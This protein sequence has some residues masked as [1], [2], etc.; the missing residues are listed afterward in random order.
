MGGKHKNQTLLIHSLV[1]NCVVQVTA[2]LCIV[3]TISR[4]YKHHEY[5]TTSPKMNVGLGHRKP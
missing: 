5:T 3:F 2:V 1:I 4:Q